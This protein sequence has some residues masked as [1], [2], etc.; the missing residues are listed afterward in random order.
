MNDTRAL[1]ELYAPSGARRRIAAAEAS[2][3]PL[4]S[5]S[6]VVWKTTNIGPRHDNDTLPFHHPSAR[7]GIHDRLNVATA[8]LA[9]RH[10][11]GVLDMTPLTASTRPAPLPNT[12]PSHAAHYSADGDIYH[13]YDE[14]LLGKHL[15]YQI[16]RECCGSDRSSAPWILPEPPSDAQSKH[17][18]YT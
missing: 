16:A 4:E 9:R 1:F 17:I 10:R 8:E 12:K 18:C 15:L 11:V 6:C 14:R 3:G 2:Q 7:H 5:R 13:G